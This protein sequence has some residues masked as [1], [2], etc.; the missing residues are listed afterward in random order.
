[1]LSPNG[2]SATLSRQNAVGELLDRKL[3]SDPASELMVLRAMVLD[4]NLIDRED[5]TSDDFYE[6]AHRKIFVAIATLRENGKPIDSRHLAR[7]LAD[8]DQLDEIGGL[9]AIRDM[10]S[11]E[12]LP[13]LTTS[14]VLALKDATARRRL[15]AAAKATIQAVYGDAQTIDLLHDAESRIDEITINKLGGSRTARPIPAHELITQHPRLHSPVIEGLL[16]REETANIIAPAKVGKSWLAYG[17]ALS[18][19]TGSD[20]LG[21]FPCRRGRVLLIDNELHKPT[22]SNRLQSVS[23]AMHVTPTEYSDGLTIWSLRGKLTDLHGIGR[24]LRKYEPGTFDL[25]I[26]DAFYR[27]VPAGTS[28]NDNAAVAGLYNA[29]D[30]IAGRLGCSWVNIH[31]SSKGSQA[32]KSVTDV[33]AGAGAQ[34]R[35][36]DAH[37]ILRPHEDPGAVVLE[38]VVRSFAPIEPVGLRWQFPLWHPDDALDPAQLR[39]RLSKGEERQL[40]RDMAGK[41]KLLGALQSGPQSVRQLRGVL[42]A[43]DDRTNR[44]LDAL[45]AAKAVAWEIDTGRGGKQRVY[46]L[47]GDTT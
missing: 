28:E 41:D 44:L 20:W 6:E 21:T 14:Y 1:M 7:Q 40:D 43:G 34:S 33:G 45:E 10:L 35:A 19:V 25:I 30:A 36:A 27:A 12:P 26:L 31:H 22:L 15:L 16:R 47:N 37:L 2:F 23:T 38:A 8:V 5:I 39:G 24:M 4:A 17:L 13:S 3:P 11:G 46:H 9:P 29:I 42:G 32:E 18:I